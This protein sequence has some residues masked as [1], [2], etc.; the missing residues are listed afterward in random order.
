MNA[1][2]FFRE[3]YH[4]IWQSHDLSKFD[5]FYAKNFEETIN[6]SDENKQPIEL[7]MNYNREIA[8]RII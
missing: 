2:K 1:E 5:E 4:S 3:M 7:M 8:R 6:V